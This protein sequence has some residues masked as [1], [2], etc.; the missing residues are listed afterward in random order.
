MIVDGHW[1]NRDLHPPTVPEG[2]LKEQEME[3][4]YELL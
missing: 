2:N 4:R 1:K 3:L